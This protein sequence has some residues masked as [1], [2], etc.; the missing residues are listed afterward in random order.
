[1]VSSF[2]WSKAEL[3]LKI[4]V[5][6]WGNAYDYILHDFIHII[7]SKQNL[8]GEWINGGQVLGLRESVTTK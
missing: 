7:V 2:L 8:N 1:M 3:F 4:I 5:Y 6:L